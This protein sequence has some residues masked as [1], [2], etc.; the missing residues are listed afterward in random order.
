MSETAL[1]SLAIVAFSFPLHEYLFYI[2]SFFVLGAGIKYI[3]DCFDE[4]VFS[5]RNGFVLAPL[6]GLFW[7]FIMAQHPAAATILGAIVLAVF[8]KGKIDNIAFTAGALVIIVALFLSG[9]AHFLWIP[10]IVIA[11]AGILDEMANDWADKRTV[12]SKPVR[13]IFEYRFIMKLSVLFFAWIGVFPWL[14]FFAFLV[15]DIGYAL[16]YEYVK[17]AI[18]N[19]KFYYHPTPNNL[20]NDH[21]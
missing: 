7:A 18:H 4:K 21:R 14:F 2:I 11:L 12:L 13:W 5:K 10:L 9:L 20:L 19:R 3:D 8:F 1:L 17:L 15:W 6:L 16:V